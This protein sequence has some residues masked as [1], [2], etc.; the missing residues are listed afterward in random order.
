MA[1]GKPPPNAWEKGKSGNPGGRPKV[2]ADVKL[3]AREHTQAAIEALVEALK[4][5]N[6]RVPAANVLLAYGY[7][8]PQQTVNVRKI[9]DVAD[10]TDEELAALAQ[11]RP[12]E[13]ET[14]H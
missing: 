1:K 12:E 13:Q 3:L 14:R 7:G 11:S 9:T 10:L 5:P 8:R 2:A 4:K 6:E